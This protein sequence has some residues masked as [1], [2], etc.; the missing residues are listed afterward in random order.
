M[1]SD[2]RFTA[3]KFYLQW[4]VRSAL[5]LAFLALLVTD[6]VESQIPGFG[7]CPS[8]TPLR[9]LNVEKFE[10]KWFEVA[11]YPSMLIKGS[12]VSMIF[13]ARDEK[14][15]SITVVQLKDNLRHSDVESAVFEKPGVW[16]SKIKTFLSKINLRKK[17]SNSK[18]FCL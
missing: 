10:G 1:A 12:C 9:G 14:L 5:I 3:V 17:S 2:V 4:M 15:I 16:T 8:V 18:K 6:L 13:K 11:K 7:R